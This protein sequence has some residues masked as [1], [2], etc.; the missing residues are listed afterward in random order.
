MP[1]FYGKYVSIREHLDYNYHQDYPESRQLLQDQIIDFFL[2]G[3]TKSTRQP[4][5]LLYTAGA[6]GSGKSHS[7][8]RLFSDP[9]NN[10]QIDLANTLIIDPDKFKDLIPEYLDLQ[11]TNP[12]NAATIVHQESGFLS[13]ILFEVALQERLNVIKDGSMVDV[14][15]HQQEIKRIREMY[16]AY[17]EIM[18]M[19]V[20]ASWYQVAKRAYERGQVTGRQI[21]Q[22]KL[23][24]VYEQVPKSVEM[25]KPL[26]DRVID[27]E[28]EDTSTIIKDV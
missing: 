22:A 16:P 3:Y 7:I 15:W 10:Y 1:H 13:E 28:N 11:Q 9:E 4:P 14:A 21:N 19:Y 8:R 27:V 20:T 26:V 17:Q 18:I 24:K 23:R 5:L 12:E 6:M 25:L 2:N